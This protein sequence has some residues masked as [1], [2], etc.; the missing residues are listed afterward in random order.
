VVSYRQNQYRLQV[1]TKTGDHLT[2]L[3]RFHCSHNPE[4]PAHSTLM[5][6]SDAR[7]V[8]QS[9][10]SVGAGMKKFSYR[11]VSEKQ[12]LDQA[13]LTTLNREL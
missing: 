13:I 9:R 3:E 6:R 7:T 1:S 8:S 11:E 4:L 10:I 2:N 5:A 12:Q